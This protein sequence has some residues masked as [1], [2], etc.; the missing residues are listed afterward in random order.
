MLPSR[1]VPAYR[2]TAEDVAAATTA[3]ATRNAIAE[4]VFSRNSDPLFL[5]NTVAL[6]DG[7]LG[8]AT[9]ARTSVCDQTRREESFYVV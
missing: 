8:F 9:G 1:L 5:C 2:C 7:Y 3:E 4:G 6:P